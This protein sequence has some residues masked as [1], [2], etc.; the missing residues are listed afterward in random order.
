MAP[1]TV[2]LSVILFPFTVEETYVISISGLF[3]TFPAHDHVVPVYDQC[4]TSPVPS[5]IVVAAA[6]K[7]DMMNIVLTNSAIPIFFIFIKS[8]LNEFEMLFLL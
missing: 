8:F 2:K 7:A 5:V 4:H 1:A 3:P 6:V